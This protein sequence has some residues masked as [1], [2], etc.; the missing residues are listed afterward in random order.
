MMQVPSDSALLFQHKPDNAGMI[1]SPGEK[2]LPK[3]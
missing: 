1:C 3:P 2:P